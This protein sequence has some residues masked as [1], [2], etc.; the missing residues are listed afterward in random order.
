MP[1]LLCNQRQQKSTGTLRSLQSSNRRMPQNHSRP[2]QVRRGEQRKKKSDRATVAVPETESA[3]PEPRENPI[4]PEANPKR[5]LLMKS[6][7]LT[8]S[9]SG[10]QRQKRSIPDD[11]SG[12]Q[13]EDTL[14]TGTGE[15]SASPVAPS[16]NIRRRIAVKSEPVAVTTQEAI[17]GHCEKAMRIA[18]VEQIELGNIM[19][20]STTGQVLRW[21]RQSNLSGGVSLRK[22]DGWNMKTHSQLTVARHLREKIHHSMLVVTV[23]E[24]AEREICS[25]ALR[26]L[27]KVVKDHIEERSVVVLVS[28]RESAIWRNASVKIVP[29]ENQL[30]YVDVEGMRVVTNSRFIAEQIKSD[31]VESVVM[32]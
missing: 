5:R 13:V 17:D 9:G 2:R 1:R 30:V 22:A 12:M 24:G 23:R 15:G 16:A 31:K 26:E 18:S 32:D 28:N 10:Q 27:L 14:E 7:S 4:E 11:E 25:A 3:A 6:A 21:A 20:I 8:A 29:Q 19:E